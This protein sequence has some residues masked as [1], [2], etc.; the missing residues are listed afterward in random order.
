MP[1][2]AKMIWLVRHAETEWSRSGRH[3]S[4]TDIPLTPSGEAR[5]RELAP[6]LAR[7]QFELVLTSPRLR[8]R[9]TAELAGFG[10]RA[11]VDDD[12]QEWDY[13]DYEGLTSDQIHQRVPGWDLWANPCPGG[14][15]MEQVA[16]RCAR[17][18]ARAESVPGNVLLFA[19]GHVSRMLAATWLELP[20]PRGRS[21]ALKAGSISVFG[22]EH[23]VRV[24]WQWDRVDV[25]EGH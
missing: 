15:T 23:D 20:P 14:E 16:A 21:F 7:E 18:V 6:I 1:N 24:L 12:L 25:F 19:H 17:V 13:G 2:R 8:A 9:R 11:Q 4:R 10:D 5:A 3:T 22:Y